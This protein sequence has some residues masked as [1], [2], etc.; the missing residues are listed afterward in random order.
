VL[1]YWTQGQVSSICVFVS[2][3]C[4]I[5]AESIGGMC[6]VPGSRPPCH[7]GCVAFSYSGEAVG[8]KFVPKYSQMVRP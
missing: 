5:H 6:W 2:L 3:W 7:P 1:R 8:D 4:G